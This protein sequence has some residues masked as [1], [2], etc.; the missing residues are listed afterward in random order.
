MCLN[1]ITLRNGI[2]VPCGKCQLCASDRRSQ[3]SIRLAIH[4][5]Y[6]DKMP[7]FIVLTYDNDNL[8]LNAEGVPTLM[9]EDVSKFLKEYKRVYHL[10]N[11]KFTY[12]GCGEYGSADFTQRPHYHLLMFGDD[13]LYDLYFKDEKLAQDRLQR[14]WNKGFCSVG[15]AQW[16]GIHY[17]TKYILKE[18][19]DYVETLGITKPFLIASKGLGNSFLSSHLAEKWRK[20]L[21]WLAY[22]AQDVYSGLPDFSLDDVASLDNA[23]SYLRLYMPSFKLF[24]DDG[25]CV[26]LPRALRKR[27]V[28]TFEHFKDS[29]LWLY[30]SLLELR[31][32]I[33]YYKN[34]GEYDAIHE[35]ESWRDALENRLK[36]INQRLLKRKF[37]KHYQHSKL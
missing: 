24:L 11:D 16:S 6:C 17:V 15:I 8:P 5:S 23:I 27:L 34:F 14:V 25:R 20:D 22:N 28:G 33:E 29:P 10:T 30:Q 19:L 9:R 1:P 31:K 35:K 26:F 12:F 13:E 2:T 4:A 37:D 32:S 36:K 3:W 18:D 21:A 7:M